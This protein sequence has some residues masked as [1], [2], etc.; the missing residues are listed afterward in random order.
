MPGNGSI[1]ACAA[2]VNDRG[3]VAMVDFVPGVK[4]T[5]DPFDFGDGRRI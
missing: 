3:L 4:H 5:Q 2:V 1:S